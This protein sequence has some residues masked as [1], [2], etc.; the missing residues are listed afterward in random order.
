MRKPRLVYAGG[1]RIGLAKGLGGQDLI[2]SER[3][4][5][6]GGT[7]VRGFAER[8]IGPLDVLDEPAGGNAVFIVN[9]EIRFP[10]I[11]IFDGV[12][13]VDLGNV[14]ASAADFNPFEVRK[15]AG[16]GLRLR[17]PYFLLRADYGWKLDRK[18]GESGGAFFFS[19]GQ[20]F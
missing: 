19:I 20:A 4:Y 14:Y 7:S 10:L 12:G 2:P 17:T 5:A 15:S 13:F 3:F 11:S 16:L 6:G 1:V 9:N 8:S 18:V